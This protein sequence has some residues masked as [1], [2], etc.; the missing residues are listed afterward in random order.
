MHLHVCHALWRCINLA[1]RHP[2]VP[3]LILDVQIGCLFEHKSHL[4]IH[5]ILRKFL[6][7]GHPLFVSF[8][9]IMLLAIF[10]V[11]SFQFGFLLL[12]YWQHYINIMINQK[13][14]KYV[15]QTRWAHGHMKSWWHVMIMHGVLM[16]SCLSRV[17]RHLLKTK[18][19][20]KICRAHSGNQNPI[21]AWYC[22]IAHAHLLDQSLSSWS[23]QNM[24]P[25]SFLVTP[26]MDLL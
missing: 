22:C 9:S 12:N 17:L 24:L 19:C 15:F 13:I 20:S 26:P 11:H 23:N 10:W 16:F 21:H 2:L 14:F 6:C 18:T 1:L 8:G 5:N 3:M 7:L 4:S 25:R